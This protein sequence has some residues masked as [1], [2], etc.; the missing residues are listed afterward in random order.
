MM[1]A[2]SM[3]A[4][5][6]AI[7]A[8]PAVPAN[9]RAGVVATGMYIPR[10]YQTAEDVAAATGIPLEVVRDKFGVTR[11]PRAGPD[12][13]ASFMAIQAARQCLEEAGQDP[14]GVDVVLWTGSEH[15]DHYVWSAGIKVQ[16]ELGCKN[17]WAIDIAARCA[18]NIIGLKLARDM[19]RADPGVDTVLLAG[20][21]RTTD[22]IDYGNPRTR[23]MFNFSDAGS[24]LLVK[25]GAGA[26]ILES[27]AITDGD[28]SEDVIIP[29]GKA[30]FDV[31][32]PEGMKARLDA[33]SLTNFVKVI[34]DS[35][36]GSGYRLRDI[37]YLALLH[38][39]RSAFEAVLAEIG[40]PPERTIYLSDYG[41]VG[42]P[43]QV[44][45]IRLALRR[46]LIRSGDLVVLASAGIGYTWAATTILWGG[47]PDAPGPN[48]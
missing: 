23:F 6:N 39:K 13:P 14:A 19:I 36:E 5:V 46:G 25:R 48:R 4:A 44:I 22:L 45:S 41:H 32:D 17:A 1:A 28:F 38:M 24:S 9:Q 10:A 35:V 42:A 2:G 31:P 34:T 29:P 11:K 16:H 3:P 20:G 37:S 15:K 40:L 26:E 7:A 8:V 30:F 47:M 18:T 43:D 27:A 21:H 12:E 33:V